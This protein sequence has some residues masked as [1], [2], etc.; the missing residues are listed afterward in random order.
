MQ[1]KYWCLKDVF[2]T[3]SG[4]SMIAA[5]LRS[6]LLF[7]S[8]NAKVFSTDG[9]KFTPHQGR[10]DGLWSTENNRGIARC[11][12]AALL[13]LSIFVT[14]R[15]PSPNGIHHGN[16]S[17]AVMV[18][19]MNWHFFSPAVFVLVP[20]EW[21]RK[22]VRI[23]FAASLSCALGKIVHVLIVLR[24]AGVVLKLYNSTHQRVRLLSVTAVFIWLVVTPLF[25]NKNIKLQFD[26]VLIG[27]YTQEP[28]EGSWT[29]FG[30]MEPLAILYYISISIL[31]WLKFSL[32][33]LNVLN[34]HLMCSSDVCELHKYTQTMSSISNLSCSFK[35]CIYLYIS[36][37]AC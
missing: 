24:T 20:S 33:K 6:M 14:G 2:P 7:S 21:A 18:F 8:V 11:F 31:R 29:L 19:I 1:S 36:H 9:V 5:K 16:N 27:S 23:T 12:L 13:L 35:P 22:A 28:S 17:S 10:L 4:D 37:P 15:K 3:H 32:T 34:I 30:Q 26:E 25:Y